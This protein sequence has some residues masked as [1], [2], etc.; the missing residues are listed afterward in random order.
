MAAIG[1]GRDRGGSPLLQEVNDALRLQERPMA[2]IG[3]GR[4]RG[5]SPLLQ[6]KSDALRL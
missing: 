4:D 5:G 1:R 6:G 2:A 3:R